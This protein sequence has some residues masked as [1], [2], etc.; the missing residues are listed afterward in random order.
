MEVLLKIVAYHAFTGPK[1]FFRVRP[2]YIHAWH[3]SHAVDH[4]SRA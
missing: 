4:M 1:A 3:R 2:S